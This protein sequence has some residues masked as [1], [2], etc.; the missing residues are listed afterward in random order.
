MQTVNKKLLPARLESLDALRGFDMFWIMGAPAI[1]ISLEQIFGGGFLTWLSEQ[2]EHVEWNGLRIMDLVFPTFLF[3]A[4]CSFPLSLSKR[5][6]KGV[7]SSGI[8]KHI[9]VRAACMF[10]L[11]CVYNGLLNFDFEHMRYASVLGR[12]GLAWM[13]ASIIYMNVRSVKARLLIP[14]LLLLIYSLIVG[15]IAAPDSPAGADIYSREGTVIGWI[16][17][18]FLPGKLFLGDFDPE[19]LLGII[20]AT[21]TALFGMMAGELL[22]NKKEYTQNKMTVILLLGGV[23]LILLG[24]IVNIWQPINKSIWS[25]PFTLIAGGISMLC[26][27]LFYW[28]IDVKGYKKWAFFFKIIGVNSLVIYLAQAIINFYGIGKYFLG[29]FASLF[30]EN[31]SVLIL[32]VGYVAACWLF[33]YFLY[34]HKVFLKI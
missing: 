11:G 32:N 8:Y 10:F 4:G 33:L 24:L 30:S 6:E 27:T 14:F 26:L 19:G 7:S 12:I 9:F 13:F 17:R 28:I 21:A 23:G 31:I 22:Q 20:P 2:M 16:D 29:G 15:F 25:T 1:V 34:K 3:I 5:R 18:M